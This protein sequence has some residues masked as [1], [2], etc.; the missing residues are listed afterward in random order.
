MTTSMRLRFVLG[1]LFAA[2]GGVAR[3]N[4]FE[5]QNQDGTGY[6]V[7]IQ[8]RGIH[9]TTKVSARGGCVNCGRSGPYPCTVTVLDTGASTSVGGPTK[10]VIK[11]GKPNAK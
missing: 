10:I 6:E 7:R 5:I 1:I 9:T 3:A 8:C 2:A 11:D 4:T